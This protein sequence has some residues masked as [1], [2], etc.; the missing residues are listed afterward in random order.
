MNTKLVCLASFS[1]L[2]GLSCQE[3]FLESDIPIESLSDIDPPYVSS[4]NQYVSTSH[5]PCEQ[6]IE[7][8]WFSLKKLQKSR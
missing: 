2:I 5:A 3:N 8:Y 1:L 7:N 4:S 6:L